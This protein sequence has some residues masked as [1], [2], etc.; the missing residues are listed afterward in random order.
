[1]PRLGLPLRNGIPSESVDAVYS[2]HNIEHLY[3]HEVPLA[4]VEFIRALNSDGFFVVTC[5]DLQS[6]C[7][8]IAEN[9]LTDA[10]YTS[11]AGPTPPI[12]PTGSQPRQSLFGRSV[13]QG[14]AWVQTGKALGSLATLAIKH[15]SFFEY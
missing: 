3:P 14:L 9:K 8:L 4:L 2:S 5:Q 6:V 10:A 1:M 13:L 11:P 15:D 7:K 12:Q